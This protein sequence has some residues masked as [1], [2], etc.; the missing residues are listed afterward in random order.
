MTK[1]VQ[2]RRGTAT[3]HTSFTGA[4]GEL[5]VN[6]TNKSVHVHD[7]VTAGGFEAARADMDNVTSSSILTAAGIT[8]T[9]AELNYV[10][11]V[12]SAI[13][14]Q[15]DGKAGTASPTFTGTL[16]T[17]NLTAT[18]TTTL[19][20]ASTSADITFG[21]ND[22]AIF[23]AGSDL[24]IYSDGTD[25]YIEERNGTGSLYIDATD[26]QLRSTA[27]AKYFRGITGGAV[28]LYYDNSSKLATTSTG[29]DITGAFTATTTGTVPTIYGGSGA[30][31]TFT[32]QSTSG[33]SNHSKVLIG[34][35][36]GADNG[37]ISFYSAGTSVATERMRISGTN[38]D[39]SFYEDTGT[40]PKFFWDASAESLA[41]GSPS[42][43]NVT[44]YSTDDVPRLEFEQGGT[45]Y[46]DIGHRGASAGARQNIFEISTKQ[47]EPMAFRTNNTERMR[48][49]SAGSVGI[50]TSSPSTYSG[51][52]NDLVVAGSG[53]RGITIA[54]TD[55]VQSNLFFADADSGSGE[56]AGYLA[57]V[58][59]TDHLAVATASAE[60]MRIASDGSVGIG[61]SSPARP[62]Q[63]AMDN[64]GATVASLKNSGAT[65]AMLG[66]QGSGS[67]ND[68]N[69]RIGVSD[70]TDFTVTTNNSEAMRIDSSGNV[71][72]G[73]T[74]SG[75]K[76]HLRNDT[77][78]T[79]I[80]LQNSAASDIYVGANGTN[81]VA[82]N[83]GSERMRI[84]SSGNL[85]V[86]TTSLGNADVGVEAR[87]NGTL[88]TTAD[89]QTAL[90][91]KR[92]GSGSNDDGELARFQNADG[93]VG[94]IGTYQGDMW[95]GTGDTTLFF[96]DGI[97]AI[98]PSG[99][100]GAGSDGQ[101]SLGYSNSRFK[102]LYLSGS[103]EIE[104][105]S[106]NV[107]VGKQALNSNTSNHNTAVGY[108]AAYTTS[109]GSAN[110]AL[111]MQALYT[112]SSGSNNTSVGLNSMYFNVSG[113]NNTAIGRDA[114]HS[115]TASNNT[116]IG[117][118]AGYS[119]TTAVQSVYLGAQAGY[120]STSA[121]NTFLGYYCGRNNTTGHANTFIGE[122]S[123]NLVSS[124]AKNTILGRYNGNQG[125]LDIRTSSNNIVL[126]DGDGN[127]RLHIDD[128][129]RIDIN[130]GQ[131]TSAMLSIRH[132][133]NEGYGIEAEQSGTYNIPYSAY[134]Q[135]ANTKVFDFRWY[136]STI[137]HI[138]N[139]GGTS[140]S[141]NTTSDYRLKENVVGLTGATD[142]LKQLEPKRFNFI[143]DAD[144]TIDGF[145]A[146]E[147]QSVVPEAITGTHNEVDVDG[148]PV[149]QG[150]DQSK[151]VPLLVATIKELEARI[152]ALENA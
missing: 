143:A 35:A 39:I 124:G 65:S 24:W 129:G 141:Y 97:D 15:I 95:I 76:L 59:S 88:T 122:S 107:G 116:A 71:G 144:T 25:S 66:F 81:L 27:N 31:Q 9:T 5:S 145:L 140:I 53:Q 68:S 136:G 2:R 54:S 106:G 50:G 112:N 121:Q 114:L 63:V 8:A 101:K 146:H 55:S 37:G 98:L 96:H 84:D 102:D 17:A 60:R 64:A 148:N 45:V 152:T 103:I 83:G 78:S 70:D 33:N 120:T 128:E 44:I 32:L 10:D 69:V 56:Y 150:I 4:E 87:A 36:V 51:S 82:F 115:N 130:N 147:V 89:S 11:G 100:S 14:T 111:G 28:D 139:S 113:S 19:A 99:T 92:I 104:N 109:S 58:H 18:G 40:T 142:R 52:A 29:V 119:N 47:S 131:S 127:P 90:F 108:R 135:N 26:L 7:N 57:Y 105:G 21:D 134:L 93:T 72:I 49:T 1:Q 125:G 138:S 77:S 3:Q 48:I 73:T 74:P 16:T 46:A 38:G 43:D 85:L 151:L 75:S 133:S 123:G 30:S 132:S 118:E 137:G 6:T 22:K 80:R 13:Q 91:V 94:S 126:S 23:G 117:Y 110:T 86:G 149:Y 12:T 41:I 20:G 34:N 42:A 67:T 79:Y 61:T 62:L